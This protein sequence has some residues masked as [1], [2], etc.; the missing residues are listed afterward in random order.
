MANNQIPTKHNIGG[1]NGGVVLEYQGFTQTRDQ[2]NLNTQV[3]YQST[4]EIIESTITGNAKWKIGTVD[5]AWG[6][7]DSINSQP[8]DGPFWKAV[9]N[10]NQPLSSGVIITIP[11]DDK[12]PTQN[13]LTVRMM[14]MPI[15]SHPHY[16]YCWN[17]SLATCQPNPYQLADISGFDAQQAQE[18]CAEHTSGGFCFMKWIQNDAELPTEP[19]IQVEGDEEFIN[20]WRVAVYMTKPGVSTY[21][22][23]TYEIREY[24]K[25]KER[26]DAAWSLAVKNG[27]LKFP[28]YGDFGLESKLFDSSHQP[29]SNPP[30]YHWLCEGGGVNYD[31]KF[32]VADC[33]YLFSPDDNGWDNPD[34]YDVAPD[35]YG[36]N[37]NNPI[38]S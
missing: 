10:Y 36:K 28:K 33:V 12:K 20:P 1:S 26:T 30:C 11:G 15:E 14:S 35:G 3:T 29:T 34:M 9:L 22:F 32:W 38:L 2:N 19:Y 13:S 7:L 25:H 4:R 17:H 24:A 23:P 6:R 21:D 31:G 8:G 27:K 16:K 37:D 18:F 5:D